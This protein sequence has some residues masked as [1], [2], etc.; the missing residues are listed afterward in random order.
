MM[1]VASIR[2]EQ[3]K[4]IQ[5]L[6][7]LRLRKDEDAWRDLIATYTGSPDK[8]SVKQLSFDQANALID[9]LGGRPVKDDNWA[10]FDKE[11]KQHL[12]ILSLL[13]QLGWTTYSAQR[14]NVPDLH[15][16][17]NWLKSNRAPVRKKLKEMTPKELTKTIGALEQMILKQ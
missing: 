7:P 14:G 16:L 17:S 1:T 13:Y 12:H 6:R 4:K 10:Y 9:R 15:H 11:N 5:S 3:I 2:P 8:T